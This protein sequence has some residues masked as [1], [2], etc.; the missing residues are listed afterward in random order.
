MI[1]S[2]LTPGHRPNADTLPEDLNIQADA[3]LDVVKQVR[4]PQR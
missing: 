4:S 2:P 1:S 3:I